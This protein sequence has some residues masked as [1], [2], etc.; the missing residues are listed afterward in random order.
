MTYWITTNIFTH[1]N[2]QKQNKYEDEF[3]IWGNKANFKDIKMD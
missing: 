2:M 3:V 1:E